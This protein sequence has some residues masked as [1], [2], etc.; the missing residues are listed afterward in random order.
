M[1]VFNKQTEAIEEGDLRSLIDNKVSERKIIEYKRALPGNSDSAKKE[2]L[3][4]ASSFANASGGQIIYGIK[5][6]KGIPIEICGLEEENPDTEISRFQSMVLAG[7]KPRIPGLYIHS[8]PLKGGK[9][10]LLI[11]IPNSWASPHMVTFK[12]QS[13]FYSRNSNGKYLLDVDDLR[14]AFIQSESI[15]DRISNFKLERLNLILTNDAPMPLNDC[16][17]IVIHIIPLESFREKPTYDLQKLSREPGSLETLAGG[18]WDD[19]FNSDG[20]ISYSKN[21]DS[22]YVLSYL[23]IFRN[24]MIEAYKELH[25]F[26]ENKKTYIASGHFECNVIK[27]M[28]VY[29]KLLNTMGVRPPILVFLSLLQIKGFHISIDRQSYFPD[30]P[31]DKRH[32]FLD[33][34]FIE[35]FDDD[36]GGLLRS[37]FDIIWNA[38]GYPGSPNYD[39]DGKWKGNVY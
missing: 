21:S 22:P 5:E 10:A 17:R 13:K 14:L 6:N 11:D 38:A 37:A 8:I 3:A 32:L 20:I 15:K 34:V 12:G 18:G 28:S 27:K 25:T 30:T 1:D 9:F 24:G 4:D 29:L 35:S 26:E 33:E 7:I 36:I 2:F 19:R 23:Q 31:I 16:S 39:K